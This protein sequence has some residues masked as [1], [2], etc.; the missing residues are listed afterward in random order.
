MQ[1]KILIA[2]SQ[3]ITGKVPTGDVMTIFVS[4]FICKMMQFS[5]RLSFWNSGKTSWIS[6]I[7]INW[8]QQ[9]DTC[10]IQSTNKTIRPAAETKANMNSSDVSNFICL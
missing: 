10:K 4:F 5:V 1:I 9:I 6:V 3:K 7:G 2:P 8:K